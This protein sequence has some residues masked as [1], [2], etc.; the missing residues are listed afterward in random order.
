[1]TAPATGPRPGDGPPDS[2]RSV[3]GVRVVPVPEWDEL[4]RR[5]GG[6]DTYTRAAYYGASAL[7]EPPGTRPVLVHYRDS[8]GEVALA[9]LL[10][11]LADGAGWDAISAY[12]YGGPVARDEPRPASFGLALDAWAR[13][14][15]VVTTFLRLHPVLGN[16]RLVPATAELVRL[17]TTVLWDVS[18]GRDLAGNLHPH[19][20]RAARRAD[21]AGVVV[22]V[23]SRPQS[24]EPFR[25]LYEL[26][27]RRNEADPFF[28]FP[29]A[30]WEA[31]LAD[32]A[33]LEPVLVEGRL[34]GELISALLCFVHGPRLHYHLGGSDE[35]ARSLG[36][37]NRCFL[38]A[39]QWAQSRAM[40]GFHLG[41][42]L[43]GRTDSP[44][45]VFKQRFDP[46]GAPL[47]FHIAKIVHD[48]RRYR[49][50]AG[51]AS[52]AG[53]FPPWRR[54]S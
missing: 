47:P 7:L 49:E 31:L 15:G 37:S 34:D 9:L 26:T 24:L 5:L 22:T 38:A 11:P 52:T 13:A 16:A 12:G 4:V 43:G 36:A 25:K 3:G 10:R 50:L 2:V 39:A 48:E 18:P 54:T 46:D 32:D 17:G 53:F 21:R 28:F 45:Q 40:T 1:M 6:L 14:N 41:G 35:T 8:D 20:R 42:G 29:E 33:V 44:L 51:T 19:H 27:M 30:Y 23:A